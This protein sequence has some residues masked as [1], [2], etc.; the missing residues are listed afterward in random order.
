MCAKVTWPT[1]V[2]RRSTFDISESAL[3]KTIIEEE[4]QRLAIEAMEAFS[5]GD[6]ATRDR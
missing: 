2:P 4:Q 6:A 1:P 3:A 5:R